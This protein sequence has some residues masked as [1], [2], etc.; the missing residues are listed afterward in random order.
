MN[1][2]ISKEIG[3]EGIHPRQ[4]LKAVGDHRKHMDLIIGLINEVEKDESA[5]LEEPKDLG[6]VVTDRLPSPPDH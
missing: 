2:A 6:L 3:I 1:Y 5:S 4:F